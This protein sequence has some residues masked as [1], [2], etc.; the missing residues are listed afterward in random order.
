MYITTQCSVI[1]S[2]NIVLLS[3]KNIWDISGSLTWESWVLSK[4]WELNEL[5]RHVL[6][7]LL[8]GCLTC[9]SHCLQVVHVQSWLSWKMQWECTVSRHSGQP[10]WSWKLKCPQS[11]QCL[12]V[13]S[14]F[15]GRLT[16]VKIV[17]NMP[18][19]HRQPPKCFKTK[20]TLWLT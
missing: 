13:I 8:R 19:W 16:R 5:C 9:L 14:S 7:S 2:H 4:L 11:N 20:Y 10:Y 6:C 12:Y 17:H 18:G 1:W 3:H 15:Q